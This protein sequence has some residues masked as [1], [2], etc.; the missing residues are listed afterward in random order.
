[1]E[2]DKKTC[3][4]FGHR[5]ISDADSIESKLYEVIENL[6][7]TNNTDAFLFGSKSEFDDLCLKVVTS[8][9]EKYPYIKRIY[10]RSA[11][12]E[13]SDD[14]RRYLLEMY[15]ETYFPEG[16]KNAGRAVYVERNYNMIDKSDVC[17]IYFKDDYLPLRRKNSRRNLF[18]YQ[19]K[20]GTGIAY[21]YAVKKNRT[22]I[23]LAKDI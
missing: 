14:Y 5:K 2:T 22:I 7:T 3:C 9:K 13:I 10:A 12:P 19:P 11:Y 18:D 21:Q 1:M 4:F 23:N 17:V 8:L 16:A 15:E 6:I 20:S